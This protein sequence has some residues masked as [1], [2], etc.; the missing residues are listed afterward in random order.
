MTDQEEE[1]VHFVS[2]IESLNNAW[3]LI[4]I[5][6]TDRGNPLIGPAFRYALVEYSKPYRESRGRGRKRR[7]DASCI[8]TDMLAL[9]ERGTDSRDQ[10]HAHSDL[11]VMDAKLYVHEVQGQRFTGI[12]QNIITGVEELPNI[13]RIQKLIEGTLDNMYAKEK[14]LAAALS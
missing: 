11:T 5:I 13:E 14:I 3:R 4:N 10:V 2:C 6:K 9:H 7:L 12:I 8:P 1:F